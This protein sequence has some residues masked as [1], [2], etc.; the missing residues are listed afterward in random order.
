MMNINTIRANLQAQIQNVYE[1]GIGVEDTATIVRSEL[2]TLLTDLQWLE[3]P[4]PALQDSVYTESC[5]H[6]YKEMLDYWLANSTN[7]YLIIETIQACRFDQ[8]K[9]P[10]QMWA[11]LGEFAREVDLHATKDWKDKTLNAFGIKR[12]VWLNKVEAIHPQVLENYR[13]LNA[14]NQLSIP[15][16][17]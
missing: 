17:R 5:R 12:N 6:L 2:T 13:K 15:A 11:R 16:G 1:T 9:S 10:V 8:L 4:L 3:K 14:T 7:L